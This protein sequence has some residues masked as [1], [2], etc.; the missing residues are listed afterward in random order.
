MY[1]RM[2]LCYIYV[3]MYSSPSTVMAPH[4]IRKFMAIP[5]IKSNEAK[6]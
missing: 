1:K 2:H 4:D 6:S 5:S 3:R